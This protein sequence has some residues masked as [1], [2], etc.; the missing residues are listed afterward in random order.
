MRNQVKVINVSALKIGYSNWLPRLEAVSS[1]RAI[2]GVNVTTELAGMVQTIYFKPG[3][4]VKKNELLVQLNADNDIAQLNSLKANAELANLTYLRDKKQYAIH[5]VSKQTL[6]NDEANLKSLNAQVAQQ[7]AIVAK[8]SIRAPF[9]GRLGIRKVNPGQY[10]NPG[11][12]VV[13]LQAL[14]PIYVDFFLPQQNL[15]KLRIGQEVNLRS[16]AVPHRSFK[17][18]ITTINPLVDVATRNVQVEATIANPNNELFPG[19]FGHVEIIVGKSSRFLVVPQTAINFNPYGAIV[20]IVRNQDAQQGKTVLVAKQRFVTTGERRGEQIKI[21][22][23]LKAGDVI[24]TSGQLKLKN[25]SL[26]AINNAI[27]LPNHPDPQL[28]NNH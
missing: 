10:I 27:T 5:A 23:G 18:K 15:A 22:K 1:L 21:L 28:K 13:T 2:R 6:D 24:V 3:T 14:D 12:E 9:A 8:K 17:G 4:T 16:D 25:G 20:Y 7:A 11:D 26:V 19:M